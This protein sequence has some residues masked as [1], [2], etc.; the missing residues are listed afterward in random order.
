V[1]N[2]KIELRE[3]GWGGMNWIDLAQERYQ[4]RVLVNVVMNLRGP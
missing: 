1:D 4:W 2:V 3:L